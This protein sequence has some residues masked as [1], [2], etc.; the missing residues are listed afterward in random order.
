METELQQVLLSTEMGEADREAALQGTDVSQVEFTYTHPVIQ[1]HEEQLIKWL[2]PRQVLL[3]KLFSLGILTED[4]VNGINTEKNKTGKIKRILR[5]V[6]DNNELD[7][8]IFALSEGNSTADNA[9]ADELRSMCD[10]MS[11]Q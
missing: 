2:N 6:D 7:N 5:I 11:T 4:Q 3:D 8:F 10:N 9:L 1:A